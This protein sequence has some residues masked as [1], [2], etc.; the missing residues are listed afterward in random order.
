MMTST[1]FTYS[2]PEFTSGKEPEYASRISLDTKPL[3]SNIRSLGNGFLGVSYQETSPGFLFDQTG[4]KTMDFGTYPKTEQEYTPA[5]INQCVSGRPNHQ[6]KR[7]DCNHLTIFTD[8]ICIYN[9]NGTLEKQLR[10]RII[11]HLFS[12]NLGMETLSEV[13]RA[14]KLIETLL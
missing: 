12:K 10:D 14:R 2:I 9:V 13:K 8:L 1:I 7:E 3:W 6:P 5:R 4:K 11:S